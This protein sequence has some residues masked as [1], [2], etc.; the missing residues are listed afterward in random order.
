MRGCIIE[1]QKP[2]SINAENNIW[3]IEGY[4]EKEYLGDSVYIEI[5]KKIAKY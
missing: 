1:A 5:S 2:F 4:L 3:A